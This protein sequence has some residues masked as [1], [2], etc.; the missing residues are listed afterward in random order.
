MDIQDS[1][2]ELLRENVFGRTYCFRG[3]RKRFTIYF[4][5]N[6]T[7]KKSTFYSTLS[8][9]FTYISSYIFI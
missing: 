3:K 5:I 2:Q 4:E 1:R 6:G 7:V 8:N 9:I